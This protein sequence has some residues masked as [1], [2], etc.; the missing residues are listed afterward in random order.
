MSS[1]TK[2]LGQVA[3]EAYWDGA[4][5]WADAVAPGDWERATQ[6]VIRA[7]KDAAGKRSVDLDAF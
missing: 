1:S 4:R 7:H 3:F 5:K 6:A 2:S